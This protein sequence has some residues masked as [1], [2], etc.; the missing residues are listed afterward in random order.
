MPDYGPDTLPRRDAAEAR[1][2]LRKILLLSVPLLAVA[3]VIAAVDPFRFLRVVELLPAAE[4][5]EVAGARDP[6]LWALARYAEAPS[7]AILLGDSRMANM[8]LPAIR[9]QSGTPFSML[10]FGGANLREMIDAFWMADSSTELRQVVMSVGFSQYAVPDP[11][12]RVGVFRSWQANALLYLINRT[13]LKST[14]ALVRNGTDTG[15]SVVGRPDMGRDEF[16]QSQLSYYGDRVMT[17]YAEHYGERARL[18]RMARYCR[19][20]GIDLTFV[21]MP[22]SPDLHERIAAYH[23]Q[24]EY[25]QF[26]NHL[27]S[28]APTID[29]D[30]DDAFWSVPSR[31]TDP[32]HVSPAGHEHVIR[33]IWPHESRVQ[34]SGPS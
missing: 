8:P 6:A 15:G 27:A 23:R 32:V 33:A 9:E 17:G 3:A 14:A 30:T 19:E 31:F 28:L 18:E 34:A 10:A 24:E 25:A 11:V 1:K 21:I 4:K 29:L 16:W 2:L 13:V 26:R 20:N 5:R 7:P 22:T 12:D